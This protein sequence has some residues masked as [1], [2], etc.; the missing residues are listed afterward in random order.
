M[1]TPLILAAAAL[2]LLAGACD[3]NTAP[4]R[5]PDAALS[6]AEDGAPL[7]PADQAVE[8]AEIAT[9]DPSA[10]NQ[11]EIDKVLAPGPGCGFS[12]TRGTDPVLVIRAPNTGGVTARGVMKIHG[13][14]IELTAQEAGGYASLIDGAAL[15]AGGV[16]AQVAP[17]EATAPSEAAKTR[18][19]DLTLTLD[20]GLNA[21]F[22]GYYTCDGPSSGG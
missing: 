5:E 14:L 10:L 15:S 2:P 8:S 19:A 1:R 22:R 6:K 20:Q 3:R 18:Q 21:G 16:T 13:R 9:T 17:V 7:V 11:A 12:L 4:A